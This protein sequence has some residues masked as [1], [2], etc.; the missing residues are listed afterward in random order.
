M[1]K[2]SIISCLALIT[3]AIPVLT[4]KEDAEVIAGIIYGIIDKE[5]LT[6]LETCVTDGD[7]FATEIIH[8]Y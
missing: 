1:K 8:A 4:P 5:G 7:I 6:E 3:Y 2:T